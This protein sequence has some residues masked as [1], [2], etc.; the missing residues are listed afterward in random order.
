MGPRHLDPGL[1]GLSPR[2]FPPLSDWWDNIPASLPPHLT[3]LVVSYFSTLSVCLCLCL[4]LCDFPFKKFQHL[5]IR[6]TIAS[7]K[8]SRSVPLTLAF[9]YLTLN[10]NDST[11]RTPN[12]CECFSSILSSGRSFEGHLA[13]LYPLNTNIRTSFEPST[14]FFLQRIHAREGNIN[15]IEDTVH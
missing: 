4:C 8:T 15:I 5:Q 1:L 3:Q 2:I 11:E 7:T 6:P 9:S 13:L 14:K 10:P 12:L